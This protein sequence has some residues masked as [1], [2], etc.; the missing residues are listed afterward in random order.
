[1]LQNRMA[2][3]LHLNN[4]SFHPKTQKHTCT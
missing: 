3:V 4:D 1:L 2:T